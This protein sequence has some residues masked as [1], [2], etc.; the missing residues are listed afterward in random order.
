[1]LAKHARLGKD[2]ARLFVMPA[3]VGEQCSDGIGPFQASDVTWLA[4]ARLLSLQMQPGLTDVDSACRSERDIAVSTT[5]K[6]ARSTGPRLVDHSVGEKMELQW[7]AL[8]ARPF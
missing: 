6:E 8:L 1:M 2:G 4:F 5:I 3:V 7:R